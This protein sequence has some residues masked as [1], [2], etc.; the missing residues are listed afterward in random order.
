MVLLLMCHRPSL[1]LNQPATHLVEQ[2]KQVW[3]KYMVWYSFELNVQPGWLM[4]SSIPL[5]LQ[6]GSVLCSKVKLMYLCHWQVGSLSCGCQHTPSYYLCRPATHLVEQGSQES[7]KR[8]FCFSLERNVDEPCM[9]WVTWWACEIKYSIHPMTWLS[10]LLKKTKS[11]TQDVPPPH[12]P[13]N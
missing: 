5:T 9:L 1:L 11:L 6:H 2:G 3:D 10:T 13:I 12:D 7:G 4:E 8:M